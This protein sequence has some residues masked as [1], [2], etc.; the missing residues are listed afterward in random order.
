MSNLR[1]PVLL[2]TFFLQMFTYGPPENIRKWMFSGG[3]KGNI[4]NKKV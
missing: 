2:L 1:Y 3:S 4:G